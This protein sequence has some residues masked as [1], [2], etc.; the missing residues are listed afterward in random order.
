MNNNILSVKFSIRFLFILITLLFLTGSRNISFGQNRLFEKAE[1][2]FSSEKLL[3]QKDTTKAKKQTVKKKVNMKIPL[4]GG[5]ITGAV[6]S[7]V[8]FI[9][10]KENEE[11]DRKGESTLGSIGPG[12]GLSAILGFIIGFPLGYWFTGV[13]ILPFIGPKDTKKESDEANKF[14]NYIIAKKHFQ[15]KGGGKKL[16]FFRY[17]YHF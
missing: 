17:I 3:N 14:Q 13:A 8:G 10:T 6:F 12:P 15:P 7:L 9:A 4:Y 5:L 11:R 1:N 2:N 16:T